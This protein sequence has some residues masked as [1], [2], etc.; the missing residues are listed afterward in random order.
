MSTNLSSFYDMGQ[1]MESSFLNYGLGGNLSGG[2]T[3]DGQGQAGANASRSGGSSYTTTAQRPD[4]HRTQS[5]FS[6]FSP[7]PN[8]LYMS[9]EN[10]G[11]R[12]ESP[13]S[14]LEALPHPSKAYAP[15]FFPVSQQPQQQQD[16]KVNTAATLGNGSG[17][18]SKVSPTSATGVG[19][20]A[21]GGRYAFA[22]SSDQPTPLHRPTAPISRPSSGQ[23]GVA[24]GLSNVGQESDPIQDLNG[25]LASLEL[26][27]DRPSSW[28]SLEV[29]SSGKRT[30]G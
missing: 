22:E 26:D 25:T 15:G 5:S 30:S 2:E 19:R 12:R 23:M 6:P 3:E 1:D 24:P 8:N 16:L 9:S 28:K 14:R 20:P 11:V 13:Y 4:L 18:S 27:R 17:A 7:D 10:V 29:T 21:S